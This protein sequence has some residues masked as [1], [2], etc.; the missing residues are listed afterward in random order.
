MRQSALKITED[1]ADDVGVLVG[2]GIGGLNTFEENHS[3][4]IDSRRKRIAPFFIPKLLSNLAPGHI[5]IRYGARR[6]NYRP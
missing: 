1:N 5:S 6:V 2:I 4:F 3:V